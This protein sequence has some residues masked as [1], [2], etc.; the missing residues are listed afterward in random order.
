MTL[1]DVSPCAQWIFRSLPVKLT[2]SFLMFV[3][4]M[5]VGCGEDK[6]QASVAE[7]AP[8][9]A[10]AQ[11][12]SK[13]N[14]AD[15]EKTVRK[16][17]L[18]P[19]PVEMQRELKSLGVDKDLKDFITGV[20]VNATSENKD[21]V[22]VATGVVIA[23]VL[24]TVLQS[25]DATLVAQLSQV[26]A[27]LG[28][29]KGGKDIA[30]Y[31]DGMIEQVKAGAG[32]RKTLLDEMDELSAVAIPELEFEGEAS[33]VPMIQAG[34]WMEGVHLIAKAS[35]AAGKPQVCDQMLKQ[36]MIV[37]YFK[38]Y[39]AQKGEDDANAVI[40]HLSA[41]L[42][43]LEAIAAKTDPM[44]ESDVSEITSLTGALLGIL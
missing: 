6:P 28:A 19:S 44:T 2:P 14:P 27:G 7:V 4:L 32:D 29:L 18:V 42:A 43:K 1:G 39:T 25:D 23:D 8:A 10:A 35:L 37:E 40:Q 20:K 3:P 16:V 12:P 5:L 17:T 36:P 34:S 26:K 38:E 9:P 31:V 15:L 13:V 21:Q 30:A 22:A 41:S 33:I 24:F 11:M